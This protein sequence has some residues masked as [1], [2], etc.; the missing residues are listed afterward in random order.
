[1][2]FL[3]AKSKLP[4]LDQLT[5]C[6]FCV[7]CEQLIKRGY[8]DENWKRHQKMN[9]LKEQCPTCLKWFRQLGKHKCSQL[10]PERPKRRRTPPRTLTNILSI[11]GD[12]RYHV[13][14]RMSR[15]EWCRESN[16]TSKQLDSFEKLISRDFDPKKDG[17][18]RRLGSGKRSEENLVIKPDIAKDFR[19]GVH[20]IV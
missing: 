5:Y 15:T 6:T 17:K 14:D 16:I 2:F 18:S 7:T 11:V 4:Q 1:M 13:P 8:N 3:N 12:Y 20:D 19:L 10:Q 9:C